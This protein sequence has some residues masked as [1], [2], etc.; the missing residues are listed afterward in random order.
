ML[1]SV[2]S[3]V[4]AQQPAGHT[5]T[6]QGHPV[7]VWEKSDGR[8]QRAILL[9][10]GRTWSSLPDFD[11]QA[12]GENLSFMDAL[13]AS[14]FRVYAVDLR[15]YG[16]TPRDSTGWNTP[17]KAAGDVQAVLDWIRG[18]NG[19]A[20]VYLFGWSL[21][22]LVAHLVVQLRPELTSGLI[23]YGYP[24]NPERWSSIEAGSDTPPRKPNTAED[25]RSDFITPGA[26]PREA[27][28]A[29]VAAALKSDPV[30]VDWKDIA[31]FGQLS[32]AAI[33]VPLLLV[34]GDLDPLVDSRVQAGLF[35]EVTGV[36]RWWVVIPGGDHAVILEKPHGKLVRAVVDFVNTVEGG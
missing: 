36:D 34:H 5:V 11:L 7:R 21:G 10:H 24:L 26:I 3:G 31:E 27:V 2:T 28:D 20:P 23:L 16:G 9:V 30:K 35:S 29:Y 32:G 18:R 22:S 19:G 25:A 8:A 33:H 14:G 6:V 12:P 17:M 13:V 15:G 4:G 1:L